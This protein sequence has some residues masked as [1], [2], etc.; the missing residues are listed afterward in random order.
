MFLEMM[1][2]RPTLGPAVGRLAKLGKAMNIVAVV[3][4]VSEVANHVD[5]GRYGPAA[6]EIYGTFMQIAI[7]WTGFIDAIQGVT[8]AYAPGLQNRPS[9]T[10]F[11]RI[12]NSLNPIGMGKTGIDAIVTLID[13][14]F[15][16]VREGKFPMLSLIHI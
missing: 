5:A 4:C 15:R 6:A 14:A 3:F 1:K 16:G 2:T 12:L 13:A 9:V 8:F 10:M 11:F 7:P